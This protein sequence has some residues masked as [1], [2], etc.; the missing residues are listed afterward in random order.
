MSASLCNYLPMFAYN[1][2][3][4]PDMNSW[5]LVGCMSFT[6]ARQVNFWQICRL[7]I[8]ARTSH[9]DHLNIVVCLRD[10]LG[11]IPL[12][13]FRDVRGLD[14]HVERRRRLLLLLHE[15]GHRAKSLMR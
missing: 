8:G 2:A 11:E 10:E 3:V 4:N 6:H 5:G 9:G 12:L 7:D 14:E 15:D 13:S 1:F